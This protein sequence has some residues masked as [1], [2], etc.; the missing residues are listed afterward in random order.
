MDDSEMEARPELQGG[1]FPEAEVIR[2]AIG[3]VLAALAPAAPARAAEAPSEASLRVLVLD[4]SGAAIPGAVVSLTAGPEAREALTDKAGAFVFEGLPIGRTSARASIDGFTPG[5]KTVTLRA[6][7][8]EATLTLPLARRAEDVSV[9]PEDRASASQG[10]GSV[11]TPAEIAALPDDPDEM[12]SALRTMAG[13]G[14]VLRVNGFSGGRLPPKS[15]IRQIRFQTNA[16][17][18]EFHE[19]GHPRIDI[20]TKPGLGSWK[21]GVKSSLRQA[22]LNARPPLAPEQPADGY[23]R[24]GLS[25]DGPLQKGQTSLAFDFDGRSTDGARTIRGVVPAGPVSEL[26]P[27]ESDKL[28]IQA[29]LESAAGAS[30]TLRGEYQ[31]LGHDRDGLAAS[32]L[33]L[34]E[35]AYAQSDVEHLARFSDTGA[36]GRSAATETLLELRLA[37]T[38][39]APASVSP[40]LQVLGAF[41]AGGAQVE[42]RRRSASLSLTQ[43][44][45]GGTKRHALRAGFR[46]EASHQ[47][48]DERRNAGGTY[49]FPSLDA[50]G[51]GQPSLYT[52]QTGDPRV[53]FD[54]VQLGLYVQ[55][56]I[57]L[58]A[59]ATLSLGVRNELQSA[60]GG[61][62][63][64]APRLGFVYGL[65]RRTTLRF[66]AGTFN[67]WFG[68]TQRAEVRRRDGQHAVEAAF[69]NPSYS[70]P[71]IAGGVGG[72]TA[73]RYLPVTALEQPTIQRASLGFERNLSATLR[74][75][76]DVSLERGRHAL[77][78]VDRNAPRGGV[79]PDPDRGNELEVVSAGRSRRRLLR[80]DGGY[81]KPGA[82][83]SGMVGYMYTDARDD[84][85]F[86]S[87]PSTAAGLRGEWGAAADDVRHRVFGFARARLLKG[88]S[89]S[90]MLRIESGSP[91][92]VTTGFDDNGDSIV[93]DRPQGLARSA[94]RGATRVNLDLRLSWSRGFGPPRSPSGP[95]THVVRIGD[96]E[97]PPDLPGPEANRR[98]QLS[99]YAQAF[100][101]TN[102]TNTRA[103]SG[104]LT[105]PF[106]GQALAAEPGRRIELGMSVSF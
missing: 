18:A 12:E 102:H 91:Y 92:E 85:D 75:H 2:L 63:H 97:G 26:A 100:N 29:R 101:A 35:R 33:D 7:R 58:G 76:V 15:Q 22:S 44:L 82:R 30:H 84:G 25:L 79:R 21:T 40:A 28:D 55:D 14:A 72:A 56:E 80:V 64:L 1:P 68:A 93:N 96:G 69:P 78:S 41:N 74:F 83:A 17:S 5:E 46:L 13:P 88:V 4:P 43:N 8:N 71:P 23:R 53:A 6:G 103:Y 39:L 106:Y 73:S 16:Y 81:M 105:S 87:V 37:R 24:L 27:Q 90:G 49:V 45:D 86:S 104:V 20:L 62:F 9:R 19:A 61:A 3:L 57:K 32:G 42:G 98:F 77:R 31:R 38:D 11:L 51:L 99:L 70:E 36:I 67:D 94:G 48:S 60:V 10:Y 95:T 54:H 50:Y 89:L 66:G 65:D 52:R 47:T 59:R 34:E